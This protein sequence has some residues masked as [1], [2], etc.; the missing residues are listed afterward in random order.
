MIVVVTII[1]STIPGSL[2]ISGQR[3]SC[4]VVGRL[5]RM[6]PAVAAPPRRAHLI[7]FKFIGVLTL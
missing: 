7:S 4:G 6:M 2:P 5:L 1:A 3:A